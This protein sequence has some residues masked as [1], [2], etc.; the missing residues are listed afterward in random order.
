M[1]NHN[2]KYF[3]LDYTHEELLAIL[4]RAADCSGLTEERV[5]EL[6]NEIQFGDVDTSGYA[7]VTYVDENGEIIW[8]KYF[9]PWYNKDVFK[10][11]ELTTVE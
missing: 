4:E 9:Q 6:I 2:P 3:I 1:A 8:E 11:L 5:I 10:I 7:K